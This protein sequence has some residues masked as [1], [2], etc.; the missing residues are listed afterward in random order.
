MTWTDRS[1]VLIEVV[2]SPLAC[3]DE[4]LRSTDISDTVIEFDVFEQVVMFCVHLEVIEHLCIVHEVS[5]FAWRWEIA[6]G[7]H[8]FRSIDH[9]RLHD[10]S[11]A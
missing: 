8:F 7:C 11:F 2:D 3:L 10:A 4:I 9:R 1:T 6:V 5:E